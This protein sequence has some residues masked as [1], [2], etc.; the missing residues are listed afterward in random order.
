VR[1]EEQKRVGGYP[2]KGKS[3]LIGFIIALGGIAAFF[4]LAIPEL[5]KDTEDASAHGTQLALHEHVTIKLFNSDKTPLVVPA[6]IGI[7]ERFW[8]YHELDHLGANG[9]A[10]LH[11]HD[12]SGTVHMESTE[13]TTFT[14]GQLFAIWGEDVT[15]IERVSTMTRQYDAGDIISDIPLRNGETLNIYLLNEQ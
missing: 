5:Q 14:I 13:Q 7:E 4:L 12:K 9:M 2:V 8:Q 6:G 11:T 1:K 3:V 15:S 10:P